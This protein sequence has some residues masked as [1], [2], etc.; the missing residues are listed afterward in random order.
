MPLKGG[1]SS[2]SS[3]FV[4]S[5]KKNKYVSSNGSENFRLGRQTF[6]FSGKK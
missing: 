4:R 6:F 2:G 5:N 1:I 3:L